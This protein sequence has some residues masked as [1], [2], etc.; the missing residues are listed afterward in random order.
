MVGQ[1]CPSMLSL[2]DLYLQE[3]NPAV[4]PQ[5]A[6]GIQGEVSSLH[7]AVSFAVRDVNI[8]PSLSLDHTIAHLIRLSLVANKRRI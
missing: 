8:S 4:P 1:F 6:P 7:Q 2:R 5:F 3:I